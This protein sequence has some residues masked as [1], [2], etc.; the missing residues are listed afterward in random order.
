MRAEI[1]LASFAWWQRLAAD[2]DEVS[3]VRLGE[4][5]SDGETHASEATGDDVGA[6]GD[7]GCR[8]AGIDGCALPLWNGTAVDA[9]RNDAATGASSFGDDRG[10]DVVDLA[11]IGDPSV[12]IDEQRRD[13]GVFLRRDS[14]E[15][16]RQ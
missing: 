6:A 11:A 7:D 12:D 1:T 14:G 15:P 5:S 4:P 10:G 8:R 9:A 13:I 16:E 3:L 2:D